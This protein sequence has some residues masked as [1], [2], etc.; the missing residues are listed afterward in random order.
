M[1]LSS[2]VFKSSKCQ[3]EIIKKIFSQFHSRQ[4]E[5]AYNTPKRGSTK[6]NSCSQQTQ[7]PLYLRHYSRCR[8]GIIIAPLLSVNLADEHAPGFHLLKASAST[9]TWL[10]LLPLT[11]I[12]NAQ[13]MLERIVRRTGIAFPWKT[14]LQQFNLLLC[15]TISGEHCQ[16]G[17]I[18]VSTHYHYQV[19]D[20]SPSRCESSALSPSISIHIYIYIYSYLYLR[21]LKWPLGSSA[22]GPR[23][24][25]FFCVDSKLAISPTPPF[26]SP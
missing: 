4:I 16:Q 2:F 19:A 22:N 25:K 1:R 24:R 26:P 7:L 14:F 9:S 13:N 3:Q 12:W 8:M 6:E 18:N 10:E 15:I 23:R 17:I 20:F 21:A 5:I 11:H